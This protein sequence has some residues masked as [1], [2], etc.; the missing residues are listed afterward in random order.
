MK[1]SVMSYRNINVH[2]RWGII[3]SSGLMAVFLIVNWALMLV[4]DHNNNEILS[5]LNKVINE[6]VIDFNLTFQLFT[7]FILILAVFV[8]IVITMPFLFLTKYQLITFLLSLLILVIS[9]AFIGGVGILLIY[10]YHDFCVFVTIKNIT[11]ILISLLPSTLAFI[12]SLFLLFFGLWL[13]VASLIKKENK[14]KLTTADN[15]YSSLS[16]STANNSGQ[17]SPFVEQTVVPTTPVFTE[18][19]PNE[20][21]GITITIHNTAGSPLPQP[22]LVDA[23]VVTNPIAKINTT[24]NVASNNEITWTP[25]QIEEVWNKGEIIENYNS[26]LYRKDYAGALMFKNN[27]INNVKID[28]DPKN[29]NWTIIYQCPL[30]HGGTANI[31]N[32]Q[33]MNNINAIT[34]GNNYPRWK[35]GVAFNGKQNVLKQKSWKD[36]K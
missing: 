14:H 28:D 6:K 2:N 36:K 13:I 10:G 33:P 26:Q 11:D 8:L 15:S 7:I 4:F 25:E 23:P 29:L 21:Q 19:I 30:S 1:M 9:I 34:K 3:I 31:S 5:L 27:F 17:N 16:E 32:L 18:H 12:C 35:T 20:N 24:T 22:K